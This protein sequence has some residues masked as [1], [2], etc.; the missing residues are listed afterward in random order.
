MTQLADT[1]VDLV[2]MGAYGHPIWREFLFGGTTAVVTRRAS[3]PVF[4]SH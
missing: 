4:M 3:V 2:V 1:E